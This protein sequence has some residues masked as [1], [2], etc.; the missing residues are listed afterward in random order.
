[1][2]LRAAYADAAART[3][4]KKYGQSEG[5]DDEWGMVGVRVESQKELIVGLRFM[6]DLVEYITESEDVSK[7]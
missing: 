3:A 5:E 2:R 1:M 6:A 7:N 4:K